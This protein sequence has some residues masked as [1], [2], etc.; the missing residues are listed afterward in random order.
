MNN[1]FS[2]EIA[3][4]GESAFDKL[5]NSTV[6]VLGAG[7]VGSYVCEGLIRAGIGNIIVVDSDVVDESNINRQIIATVETVGEPK[8]ELA[9]KRAIKINPDINVTAIKMH[10]DKTNVAEILKNIDYVA[11]AIDTVSSKICVAEHCFN[12][13][14]PLI[15]A[16]GTGNKLGYEFK[17]CDIS[18]THTD[19]LAR[20]L[21]KELKT[22]GIEKLKVV[23]SEEKP[24]NIVFSK[25][26][27]N[28]PA[29]ISYPPGIC[30]LI[31]AGEIIREI[32]EG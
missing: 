31:I 9:K 16:L 28:A 19:P 1:I 15:C 3:L 8:T 26:G 12:N 24:K 25:N 4:I 29:S 2:R 27:R 6:C 30:G 14:I 32:I 23:F 18:K 21:R 10:I 7:G 13:N 22:L 20:V 5:K 17:V 11:D